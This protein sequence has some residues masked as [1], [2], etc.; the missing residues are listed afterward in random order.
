MDSRIE[1]KAPK[2]VQRDFIEKG[3][4]QGFFRLI[5]VLS[6]L[7]VLSEEV[8]LDLFLISYGRITPE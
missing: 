4:D 7:L 3:F 2:F 1:S 8:N 5:E 6:H